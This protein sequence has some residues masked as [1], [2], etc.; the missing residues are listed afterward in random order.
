MDGSAAFW[1]AK[2]AH[3]ERAKPPDARAC[4]VGLIAA[5][6]STGIAW[7]LWKHHYPAFTSEYDC[8]L[9]LSPTRLACI[10]GAV[11]AIVAIASAVVAVADAFDQYANKDYLFQYHTATI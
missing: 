6:L 7:R 3:R 9:P 10:P 4:S 1:L 8:W 11:F 5:L 2:Q